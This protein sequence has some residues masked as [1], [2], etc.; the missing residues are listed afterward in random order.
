MVDPNAPIHFTLLDTAIVNA[1]AGS[2]AIQGYDPMPDGVTIDESK[3]GT[4]LSIRADPKAMMGVGSVHFTL[5]GMYTHTENSAPYTL[6]GDDGKGTVNP[7]PLGGDGAHWVTATIYSE[8]DLGGV[9]G[10]S[11]ELHYTIAGAP[12]A[13]AGGQ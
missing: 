2:S 12:I 7:C 8:P 9:E 11:V 5:D 10:A 6:C 13:D 4:T 1:D 3:V